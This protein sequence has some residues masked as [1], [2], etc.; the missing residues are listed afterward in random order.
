MSDKH[1][2]TPKGVDN[3]AR[4]FRAAGDRLNCMSSERAEISTGTTS[5]TTTWLAH[6][7]IQPGR[8]HAGSE[9][10]PPQIFVDAVLPSDRQHRLQKGSAR[11]RPPRSGR[12]NRYLNHHKA[13]SAASR[14]SAI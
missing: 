2:H 4:H 5:G 14:Q 12:V 9:S 8:K 11:K 3:V 1:L 7:N 13:R 10:P 6:D